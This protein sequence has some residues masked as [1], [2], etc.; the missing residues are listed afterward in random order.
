MLRRRCRKI[1]NG[2]N[3]KKLTVQEVK[4]RRKRKC[5]R[6]KEKKRTREQITLQNA[7]FTQT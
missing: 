4:N 3:K 2:K 7:I 1:K 6:E 5:K